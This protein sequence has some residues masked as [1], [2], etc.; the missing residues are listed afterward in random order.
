[1]FEN[2]HSYR[3]LLRKSLLSRLKN[4]IT[5]YNWWYLNFYLMPSTWDKRNFSRTLIYE[6]CLYLSP[7]CFIFF[8]TYWFLSSKYDLIQFI[9][10]LSNPYASSLASRISCETVS[11]TELRSY[12]MTMISFLF[13]VLIALILIWFF[14]EAKLKCPQEFVGLKVFLNLHCQ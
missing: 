12:K 13:W 11:N 9:E 10:F 2:F 14:S 1:M 6:E 4:K 7:V 3:L 8:Q 5:S